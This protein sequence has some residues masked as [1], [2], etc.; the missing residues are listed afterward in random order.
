MSGMNRRKKCLS[1]D[2]SIFDHQIETDANATQY[3]QLILIIQW[4]E[5]QNVMGFFFSISKN[6]I[7][8]FIWWF[9]FLER[10]LIV[11]SMRILWSWQ[12]NYCIFFISN[13]KQSK[14]SI[15]EPVIFSLFKQLHTSCFSASIQCI[16]QHFEAPAFMVCVRKSLF[17][18]FV[19]KSHSVW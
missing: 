8:S 7:T 14:S 12:F 10:L 18:S 11:M 19:M 1:D 2:R 9:S 3:G 17:L 13:I 15:D 5:L 16:A 6:V 4:K